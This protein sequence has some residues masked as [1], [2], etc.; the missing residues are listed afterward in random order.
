MNSFRC[1]CWQL[2]D[3]NGEISLDRLN[4]RDQR[5]LLSNAGKSTLKH[6]QQERRHVISIILNSVIDKRMK[7][8]IF[9]CRQ[10]S[11]YSVVL[12]VILYVLR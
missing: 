5:Q 3:I 12:G 4:Y 9:A 2:E 7:C 6:L 8:Y 1:V 10:V 11:H